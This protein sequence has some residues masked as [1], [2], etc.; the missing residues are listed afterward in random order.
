[1]AKSNMRV[2]KAETLGE[3][4]FYGILKAIFYPVKYLTLLPFF[5]INH[6][7]VRKPQVE[8]SSVCI[9]EN[10]DEKTFRNADAIDKLN[11]GFEG[12]TSI[13]DIIK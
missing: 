10:K 7:F 2:I 12:C 11:E 3:K 6:T 9:S 5:F 13:T 4:I 8:K 1:M